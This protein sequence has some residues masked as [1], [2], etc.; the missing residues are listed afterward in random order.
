VSNQ[1]RDQQE[2]MESGLDLDRFH[3]L[4]GRMTALIVDDDPDTVTLLK[5]T[6]QR[7]GINVISASDGSAALKKCVQTNP[8]AILLDLMMPIM[9]GWETLKRLRALTNTPVLVVSAINQESEVVRALQEGADDYIRKPF[10]AQELIA[11]IE[12]ATRRA[13]GREQLDVLIFPDSDITI[14]LKTHMVEIEGRQIRLTPNEFS[15]L[16]ILARRSNEPVPYEELGNRVWEDYSPK[17]KKRL[18][19]VI[20]SLR[21]KLVSERSKSDIIVNLAQFGYQFN[22]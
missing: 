13:G 20:H 9:D 1:W 2:Q 12:A 11:R 14:H 17:I 19:W 15:V 18:K 21:Q 10:S 6:L 4:G 3:E 5:A 7:E 16:S 8:D 22:P